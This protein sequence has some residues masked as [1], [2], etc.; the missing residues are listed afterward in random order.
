MEKYSSVSVVGGGKIRSD[1]LHERE[2]ERGQCPVQPVKG[3]IVTCVLYKLKLVSNR[4]GGDGER[5]RP[6]N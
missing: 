6:I 3:H 5:N 4:G 1:R 2:R